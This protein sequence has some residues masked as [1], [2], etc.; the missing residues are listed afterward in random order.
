VNGA[1][2]ILLLLAPALA[3]CGAGADEGDAALAS[4]YDRTLR[5]SELRQ[6]IPIGL[7]PADSAAMAE[8]YIDNWMRQQVEL[9]H[10]EQNLEP[11]RK[12]FEAELRDYRN[13]LLL[14]AYEEE[15][16]RQR[17]DTVIPQGEIEAYYQVHAEDFDLPD[18]L[19]RARWF[20][21]PADDRK[22][23]K[24]LQ[25]RFLSGR[26]D[27]M[28]EVE[29]ALVQRGIAIQDRSAQWLTAA[30]LRNEVPIEA[31]PSVGERGQR[32]VVPSGGNAWF[33]DIVELR[34]RH[35]PAPIELVRQDIRTILLNQRKLELLARMRQDLYDQAL[36]AQH[37]KRY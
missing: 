11:A 37:A 27:D 21:L 4:A 24:R 5:W 29:I 8:A 25:D 30:E 6:V 3:A 32:L 26:P 33:I 34:P 13:S 14:F 18:D 19:V 2:R 7:P 9:H 31:L 22:A 10:A 20:A 28:R 17:L 36:A 1:L 12:E 15:L 35:A 16:V 23:L